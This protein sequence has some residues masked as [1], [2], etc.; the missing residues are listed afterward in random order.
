MIF[1]DLF[2]LNSLIIEVLGKSLLEYDK[3]WMV[4][5]FD[6]GGGGG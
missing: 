1:E 6:Q 4:L 5:A 2:A 3:G